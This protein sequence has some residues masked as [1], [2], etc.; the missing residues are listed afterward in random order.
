MLVDDHQI[1]REGL[2]GMLQTEPGIEVV[3][4]ASNGS[5]AVRLAARHQPDVVLMDIRMPELDGIEATRQIKAK[6]P[7]VAVIMLTMYA[8]DVYVV[9]AVRAGA[10]GYVLKDIDRDELMRTIEAVASGGTVID[11]QLLRRALRGVTGQQS[12][13]L[14]K[15][16]PRELEVLRLVVEGKTNRD[17]AGQLIIAEETAKKHVQN[18]ISKLRASDRTQAAVIAVRSGLVG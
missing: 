3:A 9:D 18:I 11:P 13:E 7:Q 15:L 4:E 1:V 14:E 16:T 6:L 17:I 2:R 12:G 8:S 5:E 10:A